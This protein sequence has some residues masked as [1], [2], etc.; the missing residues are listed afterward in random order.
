MSLLRFR[1][2]SAALAVLLPLHAHAQRADENA[3]TS[4]DDAFGTKVGDQ[5]IGLYDAENVRGFSPRAAGNL[6]IEG[7]YFDQQT[8]GTNRC[9]VVE[10]TVRVGLAAQ[11]FDTPSPTGIANYTLHGAGPANG[12][13][14]ALIRGPFLTTGLDLDAQ[15]VSRSGDFGVGLCFH[16]RSNMDIDLAHRSHAKT[17]GVVTNWRPSARMEWVAFW[18]DD[19]GDEHDELPSVYVNGLDLPPSFVTRE[20]PTQR[21]ATWTWHETTAGTILR[22]TAGGNWSWAGGVFYTHERDPV[23]F[24][25]LFDDL[26]ADRTVRHEVDI[27]PPHA[28]RST[29]GEF[30]VLHRSRKGNR[31]Q[32]WSIALRG[33]NLARQFG[34]DFFH[35]YTDKFG[36][37]SI[38]EHRALPVPDYFFTAGSVDHVQQLGLGL[39]FEQRW[40]E[41]GSISVG[42]QKV[43][44]RRAISSPNGTTRG[45][46]TPTL[47]NLRFTYLPHPKLEVYGG[48]TRGLE[49]SAPAPTNAA[50]P[51]ATAPATATWQVDAG[52]RLTPRAG[53]Q[54]VAGVFQIQ[55]AY[56][57]LGAG[58]F[59]GQLGHVRHRGIEASATLSG[60]N[61]LTAVLGGVWLRPSLLLDPSAVD[62]NGGVPL[63]VIPLLLDAD[64]DYAPLHWGPW[65]AGAQIK[66]VSSRPA[67]AQDLPEYWLLSAS[68]RYRTSIYGRT[69]VL[70]LDAADL[71]DATD[72]DILT[73]GAAVSEQGRRLTATLTMDF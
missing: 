51:Y 67:G 46:S 19:I 72:I 63:G 18:G 64:L 54:L 65:S 4:A 29:S 42:T 61:G 3:V 32:L 48:Y 58:G 11:F 21:W 66:R 2:I 39:S 55:K 41:R 26:R 31:E 56:F 13:S 22:S 53:A 9:V 50:N 37:F 36:R 60:E 33:R 57:N 45:H 38:D 23:V 24:N 71:N 52:L 8:Y 69:C 25:D 20:L 59:Y 70:R 28:T 7:L 68:A 49:D 44:Y 40:D 35:D 5:A 10:E 27:L 62:P 47:A 6:R 43:D 14:A 30:R 34:G 1:W 17:R 16:A 12:A 15:R 73:T